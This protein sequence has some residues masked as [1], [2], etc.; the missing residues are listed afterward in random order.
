[1]GWF[2]KIHP[3][4]RFTLNRNYG[5]DISKFYYGGYVLVNGKG[6][7]A[8]NHSQPALEIV[9]AMVVGTMT[10]QS[11][12]RE[13][14]FYLQARREVAEDT[15]TFEFSHAM[16]EVLPNHKKWYNDLNYVGRHF[17]IRSMKSPLIK[18]QYTISQVML[19]DNLREIYSIVDQ[20]LNEEFPLIFDE[21]FFDNQDCDG[22][23][24]TMKDYKRKKGL[25]TY[26]SN[27]M[28]PGEDIL[29][30]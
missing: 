11:K 27:V 9:R 29:Q 7:R 24:F 25:A 22:I 20:I 10:E 21:N 2:E 28:L 5:R 19:H 14:D 4:G 30:R 12:V 26:L 6:I 17:S 15:Y 16:Q 18:R 8:Y 1:V 23:S 13:H 3:G